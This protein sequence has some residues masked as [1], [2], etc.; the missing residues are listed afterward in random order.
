VVA[1]RT[2]TLSIS[3]AIA[4]QPHRKSTPRAIAARYLYLTPHHSNAGSAAAPAITIWP[5]QPLHHSPSTQLSHAFLLM[6]ARPPSAHAELQLQRQLRC[7]WSNFSALTR[8]RLSLHKLVIFIRYAR[9]DTVQAWLPSKKYSP[10][11]VAD[12]GILVPSITIEW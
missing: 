10:L 3:S 11:T 8:F 1:S 7:R 4:V 12:L 6:P 5:S 2:V 9:Y